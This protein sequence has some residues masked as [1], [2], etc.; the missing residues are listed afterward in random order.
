MDMAPL[1]KRDHHNKVW[2]KKFEDII[3]F[4]HDHGGRMDT[5]CRKNKQLSYWIGKQ[6]KIYC[7]FLRDDNTPL[8]PE[9]KSDLEN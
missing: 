8:T 5:K 9:L 7:Q 2:Y 3:N 1:K 4:Q 6:R